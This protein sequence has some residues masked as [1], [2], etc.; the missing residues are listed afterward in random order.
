MLKDWFNRFEILS[1]SLSYD[2]CGHETLTGGKK[3]HCGLVQ[4]ITK[5]E[6]SMFLQREQTPQRE[7]GGNVKKKSGPAEGED[8]LFFSLN[9]LVNITLSIFFS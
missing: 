1:I 9:H 5:N 3:A 7:S 4:E 2:T 6:K 8:G